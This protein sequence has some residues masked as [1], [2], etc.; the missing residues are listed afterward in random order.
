MGTEMDWI[1]SDGSWRPASDNWMNFKRAMCYQKPYLFLMNTNYKLFTPDLVEKYFQRS[2]FY[3]MLPSMFSHNAADDPYWRAPNLYNRDRNLFK[4]YIP[5]IKKIAEA[6]WEPVT[7][8]VTD[9][10]A[11]YI[12]RFGPDGD[13]N[14]YFTLLNDSSETLETNVTIMSSEL[15]LTNTE[16]V[17]DIISGENI[18]LIGN[19][20]IKLTVKMA[21]EQVRLFRIRE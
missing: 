3:G 2:L 12:E 8:A 16:N 17:E 7:Y 9:K 15:K 18:K 6:G 19:G 11:V 20:D 13:G 14:V 1:G 5:I 10:D 4:R 21:P